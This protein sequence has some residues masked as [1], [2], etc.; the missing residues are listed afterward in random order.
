MPSGPLSRLC[1][2]SR[3][4][5]PSANHGLH[6]DGAISPKLWIQAVQGH[7]D[8]VSKCPVKTGSCK[9]IGL[10]KRAGNMLFGPKSTHRVHT[11]VSCSGAQLSVGLEA[12]RTS[13]NVV[14]A[15]GV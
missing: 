7:G 9:S 4:R 8:H 2:S 5:M 12:F 6:G 10:K 13:V 15:V 14:F 3:E 1:V 11:E